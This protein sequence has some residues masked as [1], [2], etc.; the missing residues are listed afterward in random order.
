MEVTR[1]HPC[2]SLIPDCTSVNFSSDLPVNN[3]F[4]LNMFQ[5]YSKKADMSI[6]Q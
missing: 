2:K 4:I 3:F 6:I 5:D 1:G